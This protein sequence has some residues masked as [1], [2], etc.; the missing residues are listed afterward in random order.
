MANREPFDTLTLITLIVTF[1]LIIILNTY[2]L[3]HHYYRGDK[4]KR[5]HY[6]MAASLVFITIR[7]IF[8]CITTVN[9]TVI[10]NEKTYP[11]ASMPED[12]QEARVLGAKTVLLGRAG[13]ALFMW[14]MKFCVLYW[15][16]AVIG[17]EK[18][19]G[20]IFDTTFWIFIVMLVT[21]LVTTFLECI[22]MQL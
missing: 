15:L 3:Y 9:L 1:I 8:I 4:W 14:A 16:E 10:F 18:K 7:F 6:W 19:W 21:V 11:L 5:L 2:R 22:P 13:Y 12:E 20:M 17:R